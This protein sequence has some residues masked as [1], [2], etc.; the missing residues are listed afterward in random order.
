MKKTVPNDTELMEVEVEV[1]VE[2]DLE[3][4]ADEVVANSDLCERLMERYGKSSA[5]QHRHLC[6]SAA[7]MRTVLQEEGLPLTP[8][9]YFAATISA[10][11]DTTATVPLSSE[12]KDSLLLDSNASSSLSSFLSILLPLIP[13]QSLPSSKANDAVSVLVSLLRIPKVAVSPPTVRSVIK[14]LGIL[15]KF[16][17]LEDWS[18]VKSP[19]ETI[20]SFSID[21]RPKVRKCAQGCIEE[22]FKSFQCSVVIREASK[23]FLS[24]FNSYMP[25]AIELNVSPVVAGSKSEMLSKPEH[26]EALHMLNALKLIIPCISTKVSLKIMSELYKLF[27]SQ[28]SPLTRHNLA[29]LEALFESSRAEVIIIP[30]A[31]NIMV[32]LASYVSSGEK[33]PIDTVFSASILLKSCLDKLHAA[34]RSIWIRNLPLVFGSIAGLLVSELNT[35][36]QAADILKELIN[37]HIDRRIFMASE[38]QPSDDK[39][40]STAESNALKFICDVFD[41]MLRSCGGDPNEHILAVISDLFLKI[42]EYSYLFLKGVVLQLAE[43]VRLANGDMTKMKHLQECIGS[44]IIAMGPEKMLTLIPV[45]LHAEEL[46]C[47]NIWLVPILK[48]YVV[49]ASLEY[50]MEQIVPLVESLHQACQKVKRSRVRKNLQTGIRALWDLLPAF[51]RYPTDTHKR[52]GSLA[53]LLIV[54]LKKEYCMHEN[55]SLALQELVNQNRNLVRSTQVVGDSGKPSTVYTV[56]ESNAGSQSVPSRY[57]KKFAIR[58]IKALASCS[59]T[60]LQALTDVFFDSSPE[61]RTYLKE[62]IGCLASITEISEVKKIFILLLEKFQSKDEMGESEKLET[63]SSVDKGVKTKVDE[64]EAQRCMIMEF[65]SSLVGGANED[66]IDII[67]DYLRPALQILMPVLLFLTFLSTLLFGILQEHTWFYSSRFDEMMDL[68]L[69]LKIPVDIMSLRSRFACFHTLLVYI[70][71]SDSE[72]KNAKAF[73]ILNEIILTL[74]DSKEEARKAAYDV[75]LQISCSLKNLSAPNSD[76]P[77]QKLFN[78]IMGYLS[79]ASPSIMSGAVAALSLLVYK[80]NDICFS[81]PELVPSVLALLQSKAKEVIKVSFHPILNPLCFCY[82]QHLLQLLCVEQVVLGFVKVLVSSLQASD[83]QKLLP[84][85]VHGVLP[86]S[87]VSRN[88]FRSKESIVTVIMEIVIRKCGS[89]SVELVIPEKFIGFLKTV[90]EVNIFISCRHKK[91]GPE[92]ELQMLVSWP[93]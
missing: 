72:K 87:S 14:S 84:D 33:N 90:K 64:Q 75:L 70:L 8:I 37:H 21:K 47:S 16:C 29:I 63:C 36:S 9:S 65:A 79:G 86:W 68:F 20:L 17:D 48:K 3:E 54:L 42:G 89:S 58:N 62:A 34:D 59:V 27:S 76:S 80:E 39:F 51:C 78:M 56:D 24:L 77:Y 43:L 53:E 32:S 69:G 81:V 73:L 85:I 45:S 7:A 93:D 46:T 19:F 1:E 57:T 41:N 6:A 22:A 40:L 91:Y 4:V 74:K 38:T 67:F 11:N 71:K 12:K 23:V 35:S 49:G 83:L 5:A 25:L 28:F 66:L 88:H 44:A 26:L 61:K 13:P 50:F 55:I 18:M 82:F 92:G 10:I 31:D 2:E 60:L 52:F 15:M 30:V